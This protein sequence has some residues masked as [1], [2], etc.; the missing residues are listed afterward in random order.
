MVLAPLYD[1]VST[2]VWP[3]LSNRFAMKYGGARTLEAMSAGSFERFAA[4]AGVDYE[5]VRVRGLSLCERI[6]HGLEMGL[7]TPGLTDRSAV[8]ALA[9]LFHYRAGRISLKLAG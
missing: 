7:D 2:V 6:M 1:L 3:E 9:T 5:M 8:S 4:D